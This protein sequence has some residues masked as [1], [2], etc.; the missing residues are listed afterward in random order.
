[1]QGLVPPTDNLAARAMQVERPPLLQHI[2][3]H[4]LH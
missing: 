2:N 4:Q 3:F 1:M